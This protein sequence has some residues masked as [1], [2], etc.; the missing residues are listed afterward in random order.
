MPRRGEGGRRAA[1][2]SL[3]LCACT[4]VHNDVIAAQYG[5]DTDSSDLIDWS[6]SAWRS[7]GLRPATVWRYRGC[8]RTWDCVG[9]ECVEAFTRAEVLARAV[10][11]L[12]R[13]T[14]AKSKGHA[15]RTGHLSWVVTASSGA[16]QCQALSVTAYRCDPPLGQ[17]AA[18]P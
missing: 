15:E 11:G 7:S 1:A 17:P 2:L 18:P 16:S 10:P 3:W 12:M 8:G 4:A 6:S 5:C 14:E 9:D 13:M